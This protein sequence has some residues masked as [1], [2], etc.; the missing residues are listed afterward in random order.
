M[1]FPHFAS[2][3]VA[4]NK[5][6]SYLIMTQSVSVSEQF[7]KAKLWDNREAC[8]T[9]GW[10]VACKHWQPGFT[11]NTPSTPT[12]FCSH[13]PKLVTKEERV[14][15]KGVAVYF[16]MAEFWRLFHLVECH[17]EQIKIWNKAS[18]W[19]SK[20]THRQRVTT[21]MT[22]IIVCPERKVP[23]GFSSCAQLSFIISFHA[24]DDEQPTQTPSPRGYM[25]RRWNINLRQMCVCAVTERW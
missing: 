2:E 5:T 14:K 8:S 21:Y 25:T 22:F 9:T 20:P 12:G 13:S 24:R 7:T 10:H 3:V 18:F 1:S 16:S 17:K 19:M 11:L 15:K 23:T 6:V 4:K